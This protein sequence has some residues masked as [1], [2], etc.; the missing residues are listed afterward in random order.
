VRGLRDAE[1][2]RGPG[3]SRPRTATPLSQLL[4]AFAVGLVF[5]G[6]IAFFTQERPSGW[7]LVVVFVAWVVFMVRQ[8]L[9][10]RP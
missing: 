2:L 5:W 8:G 10:R 7:V 1:V 6:T 3:V 4:A 9:T